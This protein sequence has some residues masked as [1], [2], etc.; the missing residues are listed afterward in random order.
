MPDQVP[1]HVKHERTNKLIGLGNQM[2]QNFVQQLRGSVQSVL[3]EQAV[4]DAEAEGY[5]GQYVR[6]RAKA[7]PGEI[8]PVRITDVQGTTAIGEIVN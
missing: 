7:K 2:E 5:T 1:E 8:R 4:D 3:F 6:V